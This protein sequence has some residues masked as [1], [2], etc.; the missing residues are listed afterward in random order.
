MNLALVLVPDRLRSVLEIHKA[1]IG[2]FM[3]IFKVGWVPLRIFNIVEDALMIYKFED[4][5]LDIHLL[6]H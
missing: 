4:T 5:I 3:S 1:V 6:P 2:F